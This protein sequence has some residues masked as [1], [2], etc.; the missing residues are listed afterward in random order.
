MKLAELL[1]RPVPEPWQDGGKLPWN[2]PGFSA[3]ML[4][5]HLDQRHDRASRRG[6]SIDRHVTWL[7]SHVLDA[8]PARVLDL[9]CG[10]GLYTQRLAALGHRCVGIDFS[11]ASIAHARAEAERGRLGCVYRFA[12]LRAGGFGTGFD[13]ALL[14]SGELN[15]FAPVEA[16]ALL[17]A[18]RDA[19]LPGGAL[20]LEVHRESFVRAVGAR[21]PGWFS[22]AESV[23]SDAPHLV[24]RE[25]FWHEL[26]RAATERWFVSDVGLRRLAEPT[27][28]RRR[29]TPGTTTRPSCRARDSRA[30]RCTR[31]SIRRR[32]TR[33]T[34]CSCSS[35]AGHDERRP[36]S[37]GPSRSRGS[38]TRSGSSRRPT[39]A[40]ARAFLLD[41]SLLPAAVLRPAHPLRGRVRAEARE[42]RPPGR[43]GVPARR[44]PRRALPRVRRRAAR[45]P[46]LPHVRHASGGRG[47]A[48]VELAEPHFAAFAFSRSSTIFSA[49]RWVQK[50]IAACTSP[51]CHTAACW[52]APPPPRRSIAAARS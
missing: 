34:A 16:K 6:E 4:R 44:R 39:S 47:L 2:D 28:A 10:P 30:A 35:G 1:A 7:H 38:T 25:S 52:T 3:R 18:A 29:R 20:V 31:R 24:L 13:A 42:L 37:S 32:A 43:S 27:S 49:K 41:G 5:E 22:A 8:R 36:S 12:D 45:R 19:L 15:T 11:P 33:P 46:G 9:G 51:H 48:G 17:A 21:P 40:R 23:F 26:E 50:S 14:L